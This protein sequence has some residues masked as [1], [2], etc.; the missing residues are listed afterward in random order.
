MRQLP[1]GT[2]IHDEVH[3][4]TYR[5]E[6]M[7]GQGGF[8]T[9]YRAVELNRNGGE[10]RGSATC[11]KLSLHADE[12][13]G[14]VYFANLLRDVGHVVEMKSAFPTKVLQNGRSKTAF[15]IN[16]EL[17]DGGTVRDECDREMVGGRRNR[18]V[19]A[20]AFCLSPWSSSTT[21]ASRTAMS[22][23]PTCSS[24]TG[25]CSSWATSASPKPN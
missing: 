19:V 16:M 6:A 7:L 9:A 1:R 20:C 14:E 17:V 8:G 5:V 2:L 21:W 12:W 3:G 4:V 24:A 25:R 18:C 15:A 22:H 23:P 13:H 10:K 11:V